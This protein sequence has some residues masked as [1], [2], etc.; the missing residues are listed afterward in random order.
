MSDSRLP[1][2]NLQSVQFIPIGNDYA[3]AIGKVEVTSNVVYNPADKSADPNGI[4]SL[5][6]GTIDNTP[7]KTCGNT[8]PTCMGHAGVITLPDRC[9]VI[10]P[11]AIN[12]VRKYLQIICHRCYK[13]LNRNLTLV[14]RPTDDPN[15]RCKNPN[16]VGPMQPLIVVTTTPMVFV[17][18]YKNGD[19]TESK[20][21]YP[22]D[23][24][25]VL[26]SITYDTLHEL[27][28]PALA[29]PKN[30]VLNKLVLTSIVTRPTV[31]IPGKDSQATMSD[32]T[33]YYS[34]IMSTVKEINSSSDETK[35]DKAYKQLISWLYSTIYSND[36]KKSDLNFAVRSA[37]Y[38]RQN[39]KAILQQL[40]RKYGRLR[41]NALGKVVCEFGRSVIISNPNI[42][43]NDIVIPLA[44]AKKLRKYIYVQ[45]YNFD[46]ASKY[47]DNALKGEYPMA[48][49]IIRPD[50]Q[51]ITLLPTLKKVQ[52]NVGD[53]IT[54]DLIS[55][56]LVLM[57]RMPTLNTGSI[58][59]HNAI[60]N[61][62]PLSKTIEIQD[63]AVSI[64]NA[65][66]DGDLMNC[67]NITRPATEVEAN[68]IMRL[69]NQFISFI[70]GSVQ[71]MHI[72]DEII[73][74][75]LMTWANIDSRKSERIKPRYSET[76]HLLFS[77]SD[78]MFLTSNNSTIPQLHLDPPDKMYTGYDI[79][80]FILPAN[81]NVTSNTKVFN[82]AFSPFIPYS[83]SSEKIVI[84]NGKMTAGVHDKSAGVI[85]R[86][87]NTI[88]GV[89]V[90]MDT[91][92]N[93]Q[94]MAMRVPSI[95]GFSVGAIDVVQPRAMRADVNDDIHNQLL[96]SYEISEKLLRGDIRAPIGKTV[97]AYIEDLQRGVLAS[98]YKNAIMRHVDMNTNPFIQD[99]MTEASGTYM[100]IQRV[101]G[102]Y[103]QVDVLG[104]RIA[105][106][107]S[108]KRTD[109]Y[110][111]RFSL[112]PEARGYVGRGFI[113][114]VT[115]AD[116]VH[117]AKSAR[118]DIVDKSQNIAIVG[119]QSRIAVF[120]MSDIVVNN[121]GICENDAG[122]IVQLMYGEDG[123]DPRFV[124]NVKIITLLM[125]DA[126]IAEAFDGCTAEELRV[127]KSDR[128]IARR[129]MLKME[130]R[131]GVQL[132]DSIQLPVNVE[133]ILSNTI[134]S[135]SALALDT[136]KPHSDAQISAMRT[137]V[138]KFVD[139]LKYIYY[140]DVQQ[141]AKAYVPMYAVF[142]LRYI[143]MTINYT[144]TT[145]RLHTISTEML[146]LT[147]KHIELRL[148]QGILHYATPIGIMTALAISAPMSQMTL[149]SIH[150]ANHVGGKSTDF[151]SMNETLKVYP[152]KKCKNPMMYVA[153]KPDTTP[154]V[155]SQIA[156]RVEMLDLSMFVEGYQIF[157]E[158]FA[159]PTHHIYGPRDKPAIDEMLGALLTTPAG[160]FVSF[161]LRY[162]LD[163]NEIMLKD[164][165]IA[166]IVKALTTPQ[167]YILYSD[168]SEPD[169]NF[170]IRIY[171]KNVSG[172]GNYLAINKYATELL[173]KRIRGLNGITSAKVVTKKENYIVESTG[174][175][176]VRDRLYLY[177]NGINMLGL[178]AMQLKIP[179]IDYTTLQCDN[180][181]ETEII[182][183][184]SAARLKIISECATIF[185]SSN[186]DYRH[187]SFTSDLMTYTGTTIGIKP[188]GPRTRNGN[189]LLQFGNESPIKV[190]EAAVTK[191][192]SARINGI[193]PSLLAG[194]TPN[195][196]TLYNKVI[197]N[198]EFI[199]SA[200]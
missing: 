23:Y 51:I 45:E 81:I 170:F 63:L 134:I 14:K 199:K 142:A 39:A 148:R 117:M 10:S 122:Y 166:D 2:V 119:Y 181:D 18:K 1:I 88:Y 131:D 156:N 16:C 89:D 68:I 21:M 200:A 97:S 24:K 144:F 54:R 76:G 37:P 107:M 128:D 188:S 133:R 44:M 8:S 28:V 100:N 72:Q 40:A 169:G 151:N 163:L 150:K 29:H 162:T 80:S 123:F 83:K 168:E 94:Q 193:T 85:Y 192:R 56:D 191:N 146:E 74:G 155:A 55:G 194:V 43:P 5:Y 111:T 32:I 175:I 118:N 167:T 124:E 57:N 121:K 160:P 108:Y 62:D 53:I 187:Y 4:A 106:T 141:K 197:I 49:I 66:F 130:M 184:I 138:T 105:Q 41:G 189:I 52:L 172:F 12:I 113:A 180:I 71:F 61:M 84:V 90:A 98:D 102:A 27:G 126:Q 50:G 176:S 132:N 22:D 173:S 103:G 149:N 157:V 35:R 177:T 129:I 115:A 127:I 95:T 110:S 36:S 152:V 33:L 112:E 145:K 31:K 196:G 11:I 198:E 185:G 101:F 3:R 79:M 91:L 186:L 137:L 140:N 147:L 60:I 143:V 183:G 86:A 139:A 25:H 17:F 73:G 182:Y 34:K 153:L 46:V 59:C 171:F 9:A 165:T 6:M 92:Y 26:C 38:S 99:T 158:E 70:T 136:A 78:V 93:M 48:G 77:K 82:S 15:R 120:N 64:Y 104:H 114:G 47:V 109:P 195:V 20:I 96:A 69:A 19:K 67:M 190:I 178:Y 7:C 58:N 159:K 164:M 116:F 75:S 161:C 154:E 13:R 42:R 179:E 87:V 174:A 135:N 30:F 65:D 125:D